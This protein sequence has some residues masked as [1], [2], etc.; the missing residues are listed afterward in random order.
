MIRRRKINTKK[1]K[2]SL[3]IVLL[4][5]IISVA[6]IQIGKTLSRYESSASTEKDLDVAFWVVDNDFQTKRML[7][8]DIYPND[9][10]FEYKFNVSNF[11]EKGKKADTDLEYEIV[12][13][14]TTN[15][16]LSYEIT[17]NGETCTKTEKLYKDDNGTYYREIKLETEKN[18]LTMEHD[19]KEDGITDEFIIKIT[20]PEESYV[21][22]SLVN[23]RQNLEYADLMED[24]KID[25]SAKQIINE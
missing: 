14:A 17:K 20:F 19:A 7:I 11:N 1:V 21:N 3:T 25:L 9:V 6:V 2:K 8:E 24:V 23:N 22:G 4:L 5:I 13:T 16:P 10:S 15:L 12:I 18:Q